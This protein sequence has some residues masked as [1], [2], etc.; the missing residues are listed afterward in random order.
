VLL[1]GL[2]KTAT[3]SIQATCVA[4]AARLQEAGWTYPQ[5][6]GGIGDRGNHG[7]VLMAF[8][9]DPLK[10]GLLRQLDVSAQP[11]Q[12][13]RF[14]RVREIAL[15][16]L[17]EA[18]RGIRLLLVAEAAS[19][20]SASELAAMKGWFTDR[21][22]RMRVVCHVRHLGPWLN[23]MVAQ[24]VNGQMRMTI[25]QAVEEFRQWGGIVRPRIQ[26]LRSVF[27]NLQVRSHEDAVRHRRGPPA[28]FLEHVGVSI[29]RSW[30]L[31]RANEGRGD[32]ATRAMSVL[33]ERFGMG[34]PA[35][36]QSSEFIRSEE[37]RSLI[38]IP[39]R[40]F[41]L[42]AHH[43]RTSGGMALSAW[44]SFLTDSWS[45]CCGTAES[46]GRGRRMPL[47]ACRAATR[48]KGNLPRLGLRQAAPAAPAQLH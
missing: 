47:P 23:S 20:M 1:A 48:M 16:R 19:T 41:A 38:E 32:A 11:G 35:G 39:G 31:V 8:R 40:K 43:S 12:Q 21:G 10:V 42:R 37:L 27:P 4:N 26:N 17:E 9:Q 3:T 25:A 7:A 13:Q 18:P 29:D 5:R 6:L 34:A 33:N 46:A 15:R 45:H 30:V 24:R 2:H 14:E 44:R 28:Y 36:F 22:W